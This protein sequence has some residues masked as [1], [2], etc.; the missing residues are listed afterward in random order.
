M[1]ATVSYASSSS[2]GVP[3]LDLGGR[4]GLVD[5]ALAVGELGRRLDPLVRQRPA[6]VGQ[7]ASPVS[8]LATAGFQLGPGVGQLLFGMGEL[9]LCLSPAVVELQLAADQQL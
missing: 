3:Y 1:L 2:L 6:A 8:Q 5:L 4:A 7:F 9:H